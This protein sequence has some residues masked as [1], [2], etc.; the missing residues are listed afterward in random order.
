M[1]KKP[2]VLVVCGDAGGAAAVVPV[3]RRLIGDGRVAVRSAVYRQA[4]DVWARHALPFLELPEAMG[5][6]DLAGLAEGADV[7]L[8]GTSVNGV[9][10]ERKLTALARD[11][12]V[13]VL[14]FWSNY[15]Q[16]FAGPGG[17]L[18]QPA[19]TCIMDE[20]ARQD[21]RLEGF[22][23]ARLVVTGQPAFDDLAGLRSS[24]GHGA[25]AAARDAAG[26]R[27]GEWLVVFASQPLAELYA[28]PEMQARH[29]GYD[30]RGV[31]RLLV[32]E[33]EKLAAAEQRGIV[34]QVRPHPREDASALDWVDAHRGWL[35]AAVSRGFDGRLSALASDLV[36]GMTSVMLVETC[37]LGCLTLSVQP[38]LK[39]P[40]ALPTNRL[41]WSRL[42]REAGELPL[43]LRELLMD[44]P[45]RAAQRERMG[46]ARA[47]G[48][49]AGRVAEV[50]YQL[51]EKRKDP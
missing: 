12:S 26:A 34:L 8:L 18:L 43:A 14:D 24:L 41:G 20:Q 19:R 40:D 16:R 33:L 35:R 51:A 50:V 47:D 23:T 17:G 22:D 6:A 37:Y 3:V 7:L 36:C 45:A 21:M 13:A 31:L 29:P 38:G 32:Q 27:P 9:D 49:A 11:R 28:R 5:D 2:E 4:K 10:Y 46:S 42:V 44:G 1:R 48:G 39:G 30:Q 15:T 25:I